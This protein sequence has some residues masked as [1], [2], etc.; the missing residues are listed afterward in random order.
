MT[1]HPQGAANAS[2]DDEPLAAFADDETA[3]RSH[4]LPALAVGLVVVLLLGAGVVW[5]R[6]RPT[7][8]KQAALEAAAACDAFDATRDSGRS[9]TDF[10]QALD[11]SRQAVTL[12]PIW[13]SLDSSLFSAIDAVVYLKKVPPNPTRVQEYAAQTMSVQYYQATQQLADQCALARAD[14]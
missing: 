12:D 7:D 1:D 2:V 9:I 11:H 14:G 3:R 13:S 5:W 6:Q 4:V 10:S 8:P